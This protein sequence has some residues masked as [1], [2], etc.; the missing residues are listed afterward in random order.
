[1]A[2]LMVMSMITHAHADTATLTPE[3]IDRM[4]IAEMKI[5]GKTLRCFQN[6]VEIIH[7]PGLQNVKDDNER[8]SGTRLDG[9]VFD[10]ILSDDV[11]C[12]IITRPN[13]Q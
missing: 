12:T 6:G 4:Y 7:E 8:I 5:P 10:M 1:M 11:T 9:N 13:K 3:Q 2:V